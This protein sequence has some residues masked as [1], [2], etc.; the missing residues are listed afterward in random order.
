VA[1]LDAFPLESGCELRTA[2]PS[3]LDASTVYVMVSV[4]VP[5]MVPAS[6]NGLTR[7]R[8]GY[9]PKGK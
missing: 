7:R 6:A 4:R 1:H 8:R 5:A 3:S 2:F 9:E